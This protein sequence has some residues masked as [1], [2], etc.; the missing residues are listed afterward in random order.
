[1]EQE[2]ELVSK[3]NTFEDMAKA[4]AKKKC[5]HCYGRGFQKI[6]VGIPLQNNYKIYYRID[7]E[8]YSISTIYCSCVINNR[9][10]Y[11]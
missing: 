2:E 3:E 6:H 1:M 10:K 4:F 9:K 11:E 7:K 5:R 8:F